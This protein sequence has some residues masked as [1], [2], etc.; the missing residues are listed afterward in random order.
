MIVTVDIIPF[1]LSGCADKGLEVL[2]IKRSN[3]NRPYHGVWALPGG[4]VFDKDLTSEGGR[5]ADENFEAARR[6]ICREKIHTYPRHF[7]EAFIDGDPKRDP[8]DWSLNITHYALVD[9]NNVEQINNAGVPECQLKWFPLQAILNEEETLAFDHQKTIE[10]AW[11]K[12]RAS[13]E[14]TSVLLF[15]LDKEFLVADIISAYQEFGI[16]ISR[17]TI[18]RRL[19][20]SGVLKPT[21]KVAST[22]KGKGGKPAMVYTLTSD[23]VTFFQNCLRG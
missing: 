13:I 9:R 2:L 22:N 6:R 4:F 5:P 17:M 11:Q 16:D 10:K 12:L 7:S 20:D 14:Y 18:K 15:A 8:E 3:P 1:R 21:N 23:E 19:I